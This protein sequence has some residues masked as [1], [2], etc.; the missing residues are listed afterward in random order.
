MASLCHPWFTT[1]NLSYRFPILNLPPPP[2][3]VLLVGTYR[4]SKPRCIYCAN[5]SKWF[6]KTHIGAVSG[7]PSPR[8]QVWQ[9]RET[10]CAVYVRIC[11]MVD[12]SS[13]DFFKGHSF[14]KS[15][16]AVVHTNMRGHSKTTWLSSQ[17]RTKQCNTQST[18]WIQ[19]KH[20]GSQAEL[21]PV[22]GLKNW[23]CFLAFV[24]LPYCHIVIPRFKALSVQWGLRLIQFL[25]NGEA[26]SY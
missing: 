26:E 11:S 13:D 18:T 19:S 3:A 1:N 7:K 12:V 2:C 17:M 21:L 10:C 25:S 6:S 9:D 15:T 5:G 20:R 16:S 8:N 22:Q 4:I 23:L 14:S 24:T